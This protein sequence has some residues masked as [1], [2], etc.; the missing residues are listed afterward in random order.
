VVVE[1][2]IGASP[3]AWRGLR[4][5]TEERVVYS[6][7]FYT[8]HE[9]THQRV[10]P[11]YLRRI[12]YPAGPQWQLG[13]WDHEL[14][15]GEI[16]RARLVLELR[17]A[18]DFAARFDVPMYVGEFGCVR[19]APDG[20][21]LRYVED[22][23][24]LFTAFGWNWCFHSFRTWSGWDA[25]IDSDDPDQNRRSDAAPVLRRLRLG[26]AAARNADELSVRGHRP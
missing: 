19:W 15:I 24:D 16:D 21:A 23:L 6:C 10:L 14:G 12:P 3:A 25:E 26:F 17:H 20:S 13:A 22:C 8:P 9:I 5:L 4:R 2:V 7:H 18:K 11:Q 1:S